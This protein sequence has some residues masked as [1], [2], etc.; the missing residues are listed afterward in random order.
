MGEVESRL[1]VMPQELEL[2]N[3]P[4]G[5]GEPLSHVVK[6]ESD[7][8]QEL[9]GGSYLGGVCALLEKLGDCGY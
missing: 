7:A 8:E 4:P 1:E 6:E 2:Q 9:G 3:S 5:R